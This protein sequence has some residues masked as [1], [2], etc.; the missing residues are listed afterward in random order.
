MTPIS[1]QGLLGDTKVR[2][3]LGEKFEIAKALCNSVFQLHSRNWLHKNLR[4][5][6]IIFFS[7]DAERKKGRKLAISATT[8]PYVIGYYHG[9]PDYDL[10]LSDLTSGEKGTEQSLHQHPGYKSGGNRF[11]KAYDYYGLGIILLELAFWRPAKELR[12]EQERKSASKTG[13]PLQGMFHRTYVTKLAE[14]MG[15]LYMEATKFCLNGVTDCDEEYVAW[16]DVSDFYT[17]VV[18]KLD[19]CHVG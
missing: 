18:S 10:F 15:K 14:V 13:E 3:T 19:A 5:D 1:L 12:E 11:Q 6:N 8:G 17:N 7:G 2:V 9:R 16:D 4:P